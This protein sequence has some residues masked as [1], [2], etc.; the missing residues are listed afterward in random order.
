MG[1]DWSR[2]LESGVKCAR[3]ELRLASGHRRSSSRQN[4]VKNAHHVAYIFA[5]FRYS[6]AVSR[7]SQYLN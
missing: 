7:L 5:A 1:G 3:L 4:E 2:G 6:R